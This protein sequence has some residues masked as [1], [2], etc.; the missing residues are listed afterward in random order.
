MKME[1]Q[2]EQLLLKVNNKYGDFFFF[3]IEARHK[4][5][6]IDRITQSILYFSHVQQFDILRILG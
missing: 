5:L 3:S 1:F 6:L 4:H 2:K